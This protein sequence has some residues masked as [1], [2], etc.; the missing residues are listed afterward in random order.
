MLSA[1]RVDASELLVKLSDDQPGGALDRLAALSLDVLLDSPFEDF[2]PVAVAV[3]ATRQALEGALASPRLLPMLEQWVE[4]AAN[5]LHDDKQSLD[6]LAPAELKDALREVLGRPFSPD[7]KLVLTIIDREQ[8]R[9]LVREIL[10]AAVI[11]FA[12]KA[13]APMA[14][15]AK[16]LGSLAQAERAIR[17]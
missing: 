7:K 12:H 1:A 6:A 4:T 16:G 14:G 15:M 5:H 2:L 11:D 9:Q 17:R 10:T 3:K 13:S 8:T